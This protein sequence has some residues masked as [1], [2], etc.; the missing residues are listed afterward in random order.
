MQSLPKLLALFLVTLFLSF[1]FNAYACL[2]PIY[3]GMKVSEGSDCSKPG[4]EPASQ[5]C[6]GFKSLAVQS[7]PDLSSSV[8]SNVVQTESLVLAFLVP[9]T[10][11]YFCFKPE[12][13]QLVSSRDICVLIS[14][15]R[16]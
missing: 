5:F 6:K 12:R 3:S 13:S 15:F 10:P 9:I 2:I 16:I 7:G 1:S 8:L 14:V 4:E 11:K